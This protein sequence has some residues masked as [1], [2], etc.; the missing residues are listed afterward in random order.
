MPNEK[1]SV[2]AL[3]RTLAEESDWATLLV[4]IENF[5]QYTEVYSEFAGDKVIQTLLAIIKSALADTD[6]LS[7]LSET[8]FLIVTKSTVAERLASFLVVAFDSVAPKFYSH[9]DT[10][11]GYM[12]LRSDDEAGQ[13]VEFVSVLLSVISSEFDTYT[14]PE[15]LINKMRRIRPLA[16]LPSKSNYI[17]DRPKISGETEK[18]LKYNKKIII[19]ENDEALELL[20]RT[21]L[22]LQGYDVLSEFEDEIIPA[23]F[24]IDTGDNMDKLDLCSRIKSNNIFANSKIIVT[25]NR[26]DKSTI[27]NTGA[28]LYLPKPYEL[29]TLIKWVEYFIKEANVNL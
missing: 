1:Y 19:L 2:R 21:T 14:N 18:L 7:R 26:H 25:S 11:R 29:S 12:L 5:R 4:N 27:L 23:L 10:K 13:R 28:D 9:E 15:H 3:K 17:V 22:E 6:F 16:K 8:E 24:I 20:L